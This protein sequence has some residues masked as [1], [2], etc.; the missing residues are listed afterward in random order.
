MVIDLNTQ[1]IMLNNFKFNHIGY[2]VKDIDKTAQF[3]IEAGYIKA[4][5]KFESSQNVY[6][7]FLSKTGMPTIELVS[8]SCEES[9]VMSILKKNGV[10]PYH[11]SYIV[12][13]IE[14]VIARL[15]SMKFILIEKPIEHDNDIFAFL[16]NK[17]V[18]LIELE[19]I[20]DRKR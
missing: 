11:I 16:Y 15:K 4:P 14:K 18:G 8:P 6:T 19:Q 1:N 12:E 9:P 13:D 17:H 2:V 20:K 10:T 7:A 3:Y 5:T